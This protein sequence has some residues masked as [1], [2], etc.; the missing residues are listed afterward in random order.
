VQSG[1]R[2]AVLLGIGALLV[3]LAGR[4]PW[5]WDLSPQK[6]NSLSEQTLSI[7][8]AVDG[9]LHV[10]LFLPDR[11]PERS[12]ATALLGAFAAGRPGFSWE[13]VDPGQ[14]PRRA[15]AAGIS[16]PGTVLLERGERRESFVAAV[17]AQGV[18]GFREQDLARAVLAVSRERKARVLVAQGPGLLSLDDAAGLA[19]M[20]ALLEFD[21]YE[22]EAWHPLTLRGGRVSEG[23]DVVILAGPHRRLP[24]PVL[25][26]LQIYLEAGGA[27]LVLLDPRGEMADSS[28][29]AGL[30]G[31]LRARGI[32][33]A[34]GFVVDLG[35]ENINLGK[36]FEVPVIARFGPH[37]VT[38][39]FLKRPELVCLPLARALDLS[40]DAA[41]RP[42]ALAVSSPKSF[43]ERGD[44]GGHV[45]FD[46]NTDRGGPLVLAAASDSSAAG[47]GPLLVV[48]DSHFVTGAHIDWR[49]NADFLLNAVAWLSRESQRLAPRPPRHDSTLLRIDRRGRRLY[50]LFSLVLLPLAVLAPW[51]LRRLWARRRRRKA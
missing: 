42:Q 33:P 37:P 44:W 27:L 35:E 40:E 34:P 48:G 50:L 25:N 10:T 22:V 49:G 19:T 29:A 36:G 15:L 46:E 21:D 51:P 31:L 12:R 7:L 28:A 26:S 43:E 41:P 1:L 18:Y 30:E 20:K 5:R 32:R 17:D 38:L 13:L 3:F 14:H 2:A 4:H 6:T 9:P 16:E 39:P 45:H 47:G 11:E 23:A 8:D 24:P